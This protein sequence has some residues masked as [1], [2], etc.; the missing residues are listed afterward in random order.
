[1]ARCLSLTGSADFRYRNFFSYSFGPQICPNRFTR[2]N[3]NA[4]L[5]TQTAQTHEAQSVV[6]TRIWGKCD[7]AVRRSSPPPNAAIQHLRAGS[8]LFQG[9]DDGSARED[10]G[11]PG[12][13]RDVVD[14]VARGAEDE[15][16]GDQL[17]GVR[18]VHH[19]GAVPGGGG[20]GGV[21]LLGGVLG[22]EGFEGGVF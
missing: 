7:V 11:V 8:S 18:G 21:V 6:G 16:G 1:M 17:W 9:F 20:E 4:L 15:L 3:P 22:G 2:Q 10:G 14:G 5:G 12:G 19:G 13:V